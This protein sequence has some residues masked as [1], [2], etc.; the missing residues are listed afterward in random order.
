MVTRISALTGLMEGTFGYMN[1]S[2][3][4][5]DETTWYIGGKVD[6]VAQSLVFAPSMDRSPHPSL[7]YNEGHA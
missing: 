7:V 5:D 1:T 2:E 3:T 6:K 4:I